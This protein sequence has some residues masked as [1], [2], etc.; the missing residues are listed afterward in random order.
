MMD[1]LLFVLLPKWKLKY[2]PLKAGKFLSL[3]LER[4]TNEITKVLQVPGTNSVR[5]R[6]S[7]VSLVVQQQVLPEGRPD[8][9]I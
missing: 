9:Y 7:R 1:M 3:D 4:L 2:I 5:P 6:F 8:Q